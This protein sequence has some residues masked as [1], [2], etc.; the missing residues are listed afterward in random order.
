MGSFS[1]TILARPHRHGAADVA[2]VAAAARRIFNRSSQFAV[3]DLA[4]ESQGAQNAIDVLTVALWVFAGVA[5]LAG[6]VTITIVLSREISLTAIDQTTQSALGLTRPNGSRS[7]AS[8][9]SRS[10]SGRLPRRRRCSGGVG[11]LPDRRGATRRTRPGCA[12]RR[13]R[14]RRR[15]GRGRRR[16][17]AHRVPRCAPDDATEPCGG[18]DAEQDGD[19]RSRRRASG[20][21]ARGDDGCTNRS[22]SGPR[23]EH[24]AGPLGDLRRGIRSSRGRGL[25]GHRCHQCVRDLDEARTA[26]PR[27][28]DAAGGNRTPMCARAS[29]AI[30]ACRC[31]RKPLVGG[32]G[33]LGSGL[34]SAA[35]WSQGFWIVAGIISAPGSR[36]FMV[37]GGVVAVVVGAR[38]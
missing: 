22:G 13:D 2:P 12:H 18:S 9:L 23:T 3:Q 38:W 33:A 29:L 27:S 26:A 32:L 21:D 30:C 14:A 34:A 7:V 24:G 6:F 31:H 5:A 15:G 16:R 8:R 19:G 35:S 11:A 36:Y 4:I 10:R 25:R 28:G 37:G 17:P 20:P 1:G